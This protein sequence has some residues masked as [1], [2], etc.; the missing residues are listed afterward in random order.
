MPQ[1]L[2]SGQWKIVDPFLHPVGAIIVADEKVKEVRFS[3]ERGRDFSTILIIKEV[4]GKPLLAGEVG[5]RKKRPY[6]RSQRYC[7]ISPDT[8]LS[9]EEWRA[10]YPTLIDLLRRWVRWTTKDWLSYNTFRTRRAIWF[11]RGEGKRRLYRSRASFQQVP[12]GVFTVSYRDRPLH[13]LI[14][15]LCDYSVF[16]RRGRAMAGTIEKDVS[17]GHF[18][19]LPQ[20]I[21]QTFFKERSLYTLKDGDLLLL[22]WLLLSLSTNSRTITMERIFREQRL[23]E[24]EIA[25]LRRRMN[26]LLRN[27]AIQQIAKQASRLLGESRVLLQQDYPAYGYTSF[28]FCLHTLKRRRS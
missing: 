16:L 9:K 19:H 6:Q 25:W 28:R 20:A 17:A 8:R 7:R 5:L 14:Y 13:T 4:Q 22:A 18:E 21:A 15:E 24:A 23:P 3:P 26:Y 1:V 27:G 11:R 2:G 12:Y 10:V